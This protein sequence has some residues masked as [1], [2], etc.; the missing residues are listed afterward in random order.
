M[1]VSTIAGYTGGGIKLPCIINDGT[2]TV[3]SKVFGP[4]GYTDTGISLGTPLYKDQ[5]VTLDTDAANTYAA[6][7]G[8][9]VVCGLSA[10][11][12][13][14]GKIITEPKFVVT[15]TS[16]SSTRATIL[17]NKWYRVATV[18]FFGIMGVAKATL[19]GASTA[20]VVPGTAALLQI[21]QSA[22]DALAAAESAETLSVYDVASGGTGLI[23]FHYVASGSATV[24]ILV[25]FTGGHAVVTA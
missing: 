24:S 8:L 3:A 18:E 14:I 1:A 6:T 22:S 17:A 11:S 4:D 19:V 2:L 12:L 13:I 20:N 23:S 25:G 16:T 5:Y 21:D 7:G 9:P 10:A 15:P